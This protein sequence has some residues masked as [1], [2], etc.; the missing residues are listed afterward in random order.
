M[1]FEGFSQEMVRFYTELQKNNN[2][3]WFEDNKPLYK[4]KVIK[5]AVAYV[6]AMGEKLRGI[7]PEVVADTRTN[8]SGAVFR[9][10]RDTRFSKDKT[11]YKTF[12]GIFLWEGKKKKMENSGFYF[13]FTPEKVMLGVGIHT[14]SKDMLRTFRD[15]V[16][17]PKKRMALEA[18]L[19]KVQFKG[20]YQIGTKHYKR[21]PRGYEDHRDNE[22]LLFNGLTASI[23][24]E[25]PEQ[26]FSSDIL[27]YCYRHF[28]VMSPIHRWLV[29]IQD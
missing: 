22:H 15:A 28:E 29:D 8:G 17:V 19:E 2:K 4:E 16:I 10:Y 26:L 20:D 25:L 3:G 24:M 14:F 11:P 12:L 13:Q 21:I 5:P 18:A 1:S 9:I 27:D 6:E 23:E 7:A